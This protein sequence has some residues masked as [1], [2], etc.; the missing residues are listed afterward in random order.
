[1]NLGHGDRL[2]HKIYSC[3][4]IQLQCEDLLVADSGSGKL[5]LKYAQVIQNT[6]DTYLFIFLFFIYVFEW[7]LVM[8]TN[9]VYF[10]K[11]NNK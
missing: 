9:A 1:M 6:S 3:L 10:I 5:L 11:P 4:I 7:S 2:L 8:L